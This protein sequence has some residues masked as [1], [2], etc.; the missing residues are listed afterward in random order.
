[1]LKKGT[2][3]R[4]RHI[5]VQVQNSKQREA[6]SISKGKTPSVDKTSHTPACERLSGTGGS[7]NN[8]FTV[9][10]ESYFQANIPQ[11]GWLPN[12]T[13]KGCGAFSSRH[14]RADV[15]Q[16][17][18]GA[19]SPPS[20]PRQMW[21]RRER[22]PDSEKDPPPPAGWTLKSPAT[23]REQSQPTAHCSRVVNT[24]SQTNPDRRRGDG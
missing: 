3:S 5:F 2:G 1:M 10:R 21:P 6:P 23:P 4:P 17:R 15:N 8:A 16:P 20:S 9:P 24:E 18:C 14:T 19:F 13:S 7:Q 22:G 12:T 11:P